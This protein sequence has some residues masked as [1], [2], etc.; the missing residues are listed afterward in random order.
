MDTRPLNRVGQRLL[1][2]RLA[3]GLSQ[4]DLAARA[5][6]DP[7]T[8]LS[9]ERGATRRPQLATLRRLATVLGVRVTWLRTG[10]GARDVPTLGQ[11]LRATREQRGL[12]LAQLAT[13]AG[14]TSDTIWRI[15]TGATRA[16]QAATVAALARA[17]EVTPGWLTAGDERADTP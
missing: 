12:T 6:V 4:L 9:I 2:A 3:R 10:A 15:E 8:I 17:L 5:G 16:P 13:R 11:R 14:L 1:A 7:G